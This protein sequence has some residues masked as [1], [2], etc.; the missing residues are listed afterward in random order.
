MSALVGTRHALRAYRVIWFNAGSLFGATVIGAPLGFVFWW[1]AARL[2]P[3]TTVGYGST[4]TSAT[5][6]LGNLGSLGFGTVVIGELTRRS[7]AAAPVITA[8]LAAAVSLSLVLGVGAALVGGRVVGNAGPDVVTLFVAGV[9]LTGAAFVLDA[10]VV[11][12]LAGSVQ[13]TRNVVFHLV[14]L[15]LMVLIGVW[16]WQAGVAELLVAWVVGV[17]ASVVWSASVLARRGLSLWCRP[18]RSFLRALPRAASAHNGVNLGLEVSQS[19]IPIVATAVVSATAG[20]SFYAAWMFL[21]FAYILPFHLGTALF[22][23]GE[24]AGKGRAATLGRRLRFSLGVSSLAGL[25]GIPAL[26]LLAPVGLR[27]FGPSYVELGTAPLRILAVAYFPVILWAHFV[28][29]CRIRGR[30]GFAAVVVLIGTALEFGGAVTGAFVDGLEGLA[31]G[32]VLAKLVE[33]AAAAP[34]VIGALRATQESVE[35]VADEGAG[36]ADR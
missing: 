23:A 34:T 35:Q 13:L 36:G 14:K 32:L 11:G 3:P 19:A 9:A 22:A 1:A 15:T 21:S 25:V 17:G 2:F 29:V 18:D 8:A 30:I 20:A 28:A 7:R 12:I 27:F 26:V 4:A 6:M 24:P 16:W 5:V 31:I 10:A 33:G